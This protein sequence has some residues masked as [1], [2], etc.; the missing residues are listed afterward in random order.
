MPESVPSDIRI[1][2]EFRVCIE[3]E[4]ESINGDRHSAVPSSPR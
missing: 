1:A 4:I 3:A 2:R